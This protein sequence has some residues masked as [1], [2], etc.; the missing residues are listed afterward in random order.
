[1]KWESNISSQHLLKEQ[2]S[3]YEDGCTQIMRFLNPRATDIFL[4]LY[5]YILCS[6]E[7]P[8]TKC[9]V[10]LSIES[11]EMATNSDW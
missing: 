3:L 6:T 10:N 9:W 11:R 8:H 5:F 1:M 7:A 4:F 2:F